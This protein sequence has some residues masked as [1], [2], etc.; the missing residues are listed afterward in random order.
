MA[1]APQEV[2]TPKPALQLA[3]KTALTGAGVGLVFSALQNALG[4]HTHGAMGVLTRTGGT[5]GFFGMSAI[6]W[7]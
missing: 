2:Y 4:T 6:R 1:E 3:S 5:I 7:P